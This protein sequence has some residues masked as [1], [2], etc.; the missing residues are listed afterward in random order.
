MRHGLDVQ[1]ATPTPLRPN[2]PAP[3]RS[4][5]V[6]LC[7]VGRSSR[8]QSS[9]SQAKGS[10]RRMQAGGHSERIGENAGVTRYLYGCTTCTSTTIRARYPTSRVT[11][12]SRR[13]HARRSSVPT[14]AP[15]L[16]PR[17]CPSSSSREP[18]DRS[19]NHRRGVRWPALRCVRAHRRGCVV[20]GSNRARRAE[21]EPT[22]ATR[23]TLMHGRGRQRDAM[24][25]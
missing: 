11:R 9:E 3:Q 22:D 18:C 12:L 4:H 25:A 23:R 1:P 17:A 14:S 7:D 5:I 24:C 21:R 16:V 2:A 20:R 10:P 19:C 6:V 8:P 13:I 15:R